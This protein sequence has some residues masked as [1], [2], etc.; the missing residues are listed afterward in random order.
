MGNSNAKLFI[1]KYEA[2]L[3]FSEGFLFLGGERVQTKNLLLEG[4]M[5]ILWNNILISQKN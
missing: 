5:D 1:G 2:K 3:E 4:G